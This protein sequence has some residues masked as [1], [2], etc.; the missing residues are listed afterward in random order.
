MAVPLTGKSSR[1]RGLDGQMKKS[2]RR[3]G[4][5]IF[6]DKKYAYSLTNIKGIVPQSWNR[7]ETGLV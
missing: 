6:I 7:F 2:I 4:I 3:K 1:T 5:K